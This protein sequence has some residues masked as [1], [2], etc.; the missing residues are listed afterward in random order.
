[1]EY[2]NLGPS[3]MKVSRLCLG[4][5][6]YGTSKWR[7]WVLDEEQSRPIIQRAVELGINFFD[8][9]DIYSMGVSEE[10]TGRALRDF[11]RREEVVIAT[12]VFN[13]YNDKPN[14]GGLSRLHILRAVEGS[15]RKLGTDYIDLYQIHRADPETPWE[16]TLA[17]L[18]D[19]V[20]SGKVRY[21]GAS[22]MYAWQFAKSLYLAD[23]HGWT[24]FIS[25]Q[26]HY[27]L[28]Y[29]E[30]EREMMPLC[31]A[32]GIGVIP[33]SPLARGFLTGN[34]TRQEWGETVRAKTD[35][36]AQ[37]M[38]YQ[39]SDFQIVDRLSAL[40]EQQGVSNA[41]LAL[42]WLLHKPGV[43]APIIGASKMKHLEEAVAALEVSLSG[44]EM[45]RLE[46]LYQPH[47]VLGHR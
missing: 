16:E 42:A 31:Q 46:E 11:A 20:Q 21:I 32:E 28:V 39:E 43:T 29:R 9:A 17:A 6:T 47:P 12:K 10:V 45:T 24:R 25:M 37:D 38:Y 5:M 35:G 26:N 41:Q 34:R 4:M 19:L 18:H 44:S 36:F 14:Q 15:L 2:I 33:W 22:S 23:L 1:M 7:P 27:N 30:E 40:A 3:G 8:T 13:P